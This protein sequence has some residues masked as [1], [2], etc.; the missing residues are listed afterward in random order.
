[1][2]SAEPSTV[3]IHSD[4]AAELGAAYA[5]QNK[6]VVATSG[7]FDLIHS[8][9]VRLLQAAR[10]LGDVLFVGLNSDRSV[11]RVKGAG[12]PLVPLAER[13]AL[14]A[15]LRSV[16]HV[17]VFDETTPE[18]FLAKLKPHIYCKGSDYSLEALPERNAVWAAGGR[19]ELIDIQSAPSTSLL[20]GRILSVYGV[21]QT[22]SES[23]STDPRDSLERIL[24]HSNALRQLAYR[25]AGR[26]VQAVNWILEGLKARERVAICGDRWTYPTC[27]QIA[28]NWLAAFAGA[29]IELL[30]GTGVSG[31]AVTVAVC[32]QVDNSFEQSL[33][34]AERMIWISPRNPGRPDSIHLSLTE[35]SLLGAT[36]QA[37]LM[38]ETMDWLVRRRPGVL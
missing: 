1:M 27:Q 37:I 5:R 7:C 23:E 3:V 22:G 32:V 11:E 29:E 4:E 24:S 15:A 25:T 34:S 9:H 6:V 20:I 18:Q 26:T 31:T 21:E 8:G 33:L 17:V 28:R 10:T 38:L 16:D 2:K 36:A 13:A 14:L 19:I 35:T 30:S 12:R